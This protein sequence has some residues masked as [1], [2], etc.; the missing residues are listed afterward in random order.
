M[1]NK[2]KAETFIGFAVRAGKMRTGLNTLSTLKRA[3]LIIVCHTAAEATIESAVKYAEKYKCAAFK[4]SVKPLED[5]IYKQ[6]V[7][8]AAVTDRGLAKAISENSGT[9]FT[10]IY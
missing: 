4:T 3:Y 8:I 10:A 2:S 7:K 5:Y 9:E 1:E 6:G